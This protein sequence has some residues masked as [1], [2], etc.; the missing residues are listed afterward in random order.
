MDK[1]S[2]PKLG[3][4]YDTPKCPPPPPRFKLE[5]KYYVLPMSGQDLGHLIFILSVAL[6]LIIN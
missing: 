1:H 2:S 4:C 3:Q 5:P 6:Y